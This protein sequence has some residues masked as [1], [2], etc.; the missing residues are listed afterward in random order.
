MKRQ[1]M[2]LHNTSKQNTRRKINGGK[3]TK[4]KYCHDVIQIQ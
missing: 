4:K 2:K 1:T 3:Q